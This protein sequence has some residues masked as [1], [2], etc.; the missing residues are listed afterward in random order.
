M[1][2]LRTRLLHQGAA[3]GHVYLAVT[4][5]EVHTSPEFKRVYVSGRQ[6]GATPTTVY[7]TAQVIEACGC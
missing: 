5:T 2:L 7:V 6:E 4:S 1:H 3:R